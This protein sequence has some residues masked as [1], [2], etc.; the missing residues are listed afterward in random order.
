M[1]LTLPKILTCLTLGAAALLPATAQAAPAFPTKSVLAEGKWVK[2]HIG[3][4]GVYEITA[5]ELAGMGFDNPQAV[6]V[7]GRGGTPQPTQFVNPGG[8]E[9]VSDLQPVAMKY[10]A[11][12]LYF[13]GQGT[14]EVRYCT[15]ND[16]STDGKRFERRGNQAY[17]DDAVY[18]LTDTPATRLIIE[19]AQGESNAQLPPLTEAWGYYYHETDLMTPV[20]AGRQFFGESFAGVGERIRTFRYC[21]PGAIAGSRAGVTVSFAAT[22]SK[23]SELTVG[24]G[25]DTKELSVPAVTDA[26]NFLSCSRNN[27]TLPIPSAEGEITLSFAPGAKDVSFAALD[28]FVVGARRALTFATGE[29]QFSVFPYSFTHNRYSCLEVEGVTDSEGTYG[30]WQVSD[31]AHVTELPCEHDGGKCRV[32]YLADNH[33]GP[34]VCV[35]YSKKQL[36]I[37]GYEA[38][39][40]QNLH[41]LGTDGMPSML[42]ITLPAY[43][44]VAER[45][46]DIHRRYDDERVDVVLHEDVV[47]EFSAG[48]NDPMAY[49]ALVKMLYDR[50]NPEKRVFKNLLLLGPNVRDQR[51]VLGKRPNVGT[52]ISN[53]VATAAQKDYTFCLNDWYGMMDD[54]T[55]CEQD[56]YSTFCGVPMHIGVGMLPVTVDEA[57][58]Y[59]DKLEAWY[60]D[61]SAAR[62]ASL[63]NYMADGGDDNEHQ[64]WQE[65]LKAQMD[66][67]T[68]GHGL[69]TKIYSNL[70]DQWSTGPM[71]IYKVNEG[72]LISY[73]TGHASYS[74]LSAD[75]FSTRDLHKLSNTYAGFLML[76]AC[77]V[78]PFDNNISGIGQRLVTMPGHGFIASLSTSREG[79]SRRNYALL[80]A[81]QR[82]LFRQSADPADDTPLREPRTLGE[83]CITAKNYCSS[84]ANKFAFHLIG[85]PAIK[86][87]VPLWGVRCEAAADGDVYPGT[88]VQVSGT[89]TDADGSDA[90]GFNGKLVARLCAP[91]VTL[92]TN[93]HKGSP[94]VTVTLDQ[95]VLGETEVAVENGR[96]ELT[97]FVPHT[98]TAGD[99]DK[100]AL[101]LSAYD[102]TTRRAALGGMALRLMPY[103]ADKAEAAD[104]PPVIEAM[105]A[106]SPDSDGMPVAPNFTLHADLSDD[107]APA[108]GAVQGVDGLCLDIDGRDLRFDLRNH[109]TFAEGG[110]RMHLAYPLENIS[111]GRHLL[112]LTATDTGGQAVS[113]LLE[114]SV[115]ATIPAPELSLEEKS[116]ART[117]ATLQCDVQPGDLCTL[118]ILDAAGA[119]VRTATMRGGSYEWDLTD[120]VSARVRPGVYYAVCHIHRPGQGSCVTAPCEIIVLNHLN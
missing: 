66:E 70:C 113:R 103:D 24:L 53:Q 11:G 119:T 67:Y 64:L 99:T 96:Y 38:V 15:E 51:N 30:F 22:C 82:A 100:L 20:S 63:Y 111:E 31:P 102:P 25:S 23:A 83:V 14:H 12:R 5:E 36:R 92:K 56:S 6:C 88:T 84:S 26:Y 10:A 59:A 46:A 7:Y 77:D 85:D 9:Y 78:A 43:K 28:Y 48:V 116:P 32:L 75:I 94:S 4:S 16:K 69:G 114:V 33:P 45:I 74:D 50:D 79:Y 73:Y 57:R 68:G 52:L 109:I 93:S 112:R 89:V 60:R 47:N 44:D 55:A 106:D 105:Y 115:G 118:S 41:A 18:F 104:Q 1:K 35:D 80:S 95:T 37:K 97:L 54:R 2:I 90:S 71:F 13:Y 86:L 61:D 39:A 3:E 98:A 107:H 17:S 42:I 117:S 27:L 49:R 34:V 40:N 72:A 120:S 58:D 8:E 101:R 62:T 29:A 91:P 21:I 81:M 19:Q 108:T 110:K 87:P 65:N 76:G